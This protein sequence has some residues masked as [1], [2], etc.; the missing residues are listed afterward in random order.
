[1]C[2]CLPVKHSRVGDG[3]R[4]FLQRRG[5]IRDQMTNS[6]CLLNSLELRR[7]HGLHVMVSGTHLSRNSLE[8]D[9]CSR[10]AEENI[11]KTYR[12]KT[13]QHFGSKVSSE[14]DEHCCSACR[15]GMSP[16]MDF[17]RKVY[18]SEKRI[19]IKCRKITSTRACA[20][21]LYSKRHTQRI[22]HCVVSRCPSH[23][24]PIHS[25]QT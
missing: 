24:K 3:E 16:A 25:V 21:D 9:V 1:M 23:C 13:R 8:M 2:V 12:S 19:G 14:L 4:E 10:R 5:Q 15:S 20:C 22:V 7:F 6:G 18:S 11:E 17:C